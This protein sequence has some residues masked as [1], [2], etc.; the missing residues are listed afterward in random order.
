MKITDTIKLECEDI[1][2]QGMGVGRYQGFLFFVP[3]LIIGDVAIVEIVE[4]K[5]NYG[6][7]KIKEILKISPYRIEPACPIYSECG[8]CS[9]LSLDYQEQLNL[10]V[11]MAEATFNRIGHLKLKVD[12]I[13]GME[14]PFRYRNKALFTFG[15]IKDEIVCGYYRQGTNEVIPLVDCKTT[16]H[17]STEIALYIKDLANLYGLSVYDNTTDSGLLRQLMLRVNRDGEYMVAMITRDDEIPHC[18]EIVTELLERYHEIKTIQQIVNRKNSNALID[19]EMRT[20]TGPG[21]L[22]DHLMGLSFIVSSQSFFQTNLYQTEKLYKKVIDYAKPEPTDIIV[23]AYCGVGTMTLIFAAYCR[24]AYG[25]EVMSEAI[26]DA[27]DNAKM[28][29][30]KNAEFFLGKAE[31]EIT[32][33]DSPIDILIV[34]PPRKGCDQVLLN[35]IIKQNIKKIIY[36]SCDVATLA[37]DLAYLAPYYKIEGVTLVD[38]F[39]HSMHVETVVMMSRK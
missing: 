16:P 26:S 5:K 2:H 37:R 23:D 10:K 9:L 21:V 24:K 18:N 8:G 13:I 29:N 39:P 35:S 6:F 15:R 27:R 38:M 30:I 11:R 14:N 36:I 12:A 32:K 33:L 25:I 22:I 1:N 17:L 28:N 31:L 20:L 34:D 19:T 4:L 7:G 3:G